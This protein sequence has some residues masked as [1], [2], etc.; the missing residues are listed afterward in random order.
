MKKLLFGLVI[1]FVYG[2][3]LCSFVQVE[4]FE[5]GFGYGWQNCGRVFEPLQ[6]F[7][8]LALLSG[9]AVIPT[10]I[11]LFIYGVFSMIMWSLKIKQR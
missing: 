6:A 11:V 4:V 5:C 3:I 7:A 10:T 1:F 2:P 8:S 9:V